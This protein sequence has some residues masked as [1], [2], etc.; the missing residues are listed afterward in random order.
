M[1]I[2]EDL[3]CRAAA[4]DDSK[5]RRRDEL[6]HAIDVSATSIHHVSQD[7]TTLHRLE[8]SSFFNVTARHCPYPYRM[9]TNPILGQILTHPD[10]SSQ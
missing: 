9:R 1:R 3:D 5:Q 8:V 4:G 2:K 6:M 10:K 7:K